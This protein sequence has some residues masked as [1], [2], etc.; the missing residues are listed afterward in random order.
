[1]V[2][3]LHATIEQ[4]HRL[5]STPDLS[6]LIVSLSTIAL[7]VRAVHYHSTIVSRT[8][9]TSRPETDHTISLIYILPT[10]GATKDIFGGFGFVSFA[11]V[12]P[13]VEDH[14]IGASAAFETVFVC[15]V[16]VAG[17]A[18]GEWD[19]GYCEHVAA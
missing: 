9:N 8:S 1:M 4:S 6:L 13:A 3:A 15:V 18:F 19:C 16:G 2:A 5:I 10:A 14:L 12:V 11:L 17:R 7:F